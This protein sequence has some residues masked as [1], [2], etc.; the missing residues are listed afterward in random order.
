MADSSLKSEQN[1]GLD[2]EKPPSSWPDP[3]QELVDNLRT[4]V[5]EAVR[6]EISQWMQSLQEKLGTYNPETKQLDP[7]GVLGA[8]HWS[9]SNAQRDIHDLKQLAEDPQRP[10]ERGE[11]P[12]RLSQR[13][14]M[15]QQDVRLL[16]QRFEEVLAAM[17]AKDVRA[18]VEV[19]E[20]TSDAYRQHESNANAYR[21]LVKHS[22]HG[23]AELLCPAGESHAKLAERRAKAASELL[24]YL[25]ENPPEGGGV[26]VES[27]R[28]KL[29][30]SG[31]ATEGEEFVLTLERLID[32]ASKIKQNM[33]RLRPAARRLC[34]EDDPADL[35][36]GEYEPWNPGPDGRRPAIIVAPAYVIDG[37]QQPLRP[38]VVFLKAPV[39]GEPEEERP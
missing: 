32:T 8:L 16:R 37:R 18:K 17:Q 4:A 9:I 13:L 27:V 1:D 3:S 28:T 7:P 10:S 39:S 19:G 20:V 35:A 31:F 22:L 34:F 38:P 33:F 24:C 5:T 36:D 2:P 6:A 23:I 25:F 29:T 12:Q 15:L 14:E 30:T 11:D 26:T 21:N